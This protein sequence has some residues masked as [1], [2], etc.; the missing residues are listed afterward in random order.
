MSN[1]LITCINIGFM[2]G[3]SLLLSLVS[4]DLVFGYIVIMATY[5]IYNKYDM[6]DEGENDDERHK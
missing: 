3:M 2:V 1:A 6:R 4:Y 5:I